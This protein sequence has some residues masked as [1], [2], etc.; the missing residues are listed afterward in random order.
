MADSVS[1]TNAPA[2]FSKGLDGIVAG[3]SSICFIDGYKGELVYR[4][5]NTDELAA[6]ATF[7]E[8]IYLLWHGSLPKKDELLKLQKELSTN[9]DLPEQVITFLRSVPK[10]SNPMDVLRTAVSLLGLYDEESSATSTEANWRKSVRL[11]AKLPTIVANFHRLRSNG[12]YLKPEP[13]LNHSANFLYMINGVEPGTTASKTLDC[14]LVLHADHEFNASTFS[15]R[16]TAATLSDIYSAIT[17][18][19]G[20]LK[21]PLHGGA[22]EDVMNMLLDIKTLNNIGPYL[23]KFFAQK[24]KVPGFGHRVYKVEDPRAKHL[25]KFSRQLGDTIGNM[26]WYEMSEKIEEYVKKEKRLVPN[27]DFYSASTYY[28]LGIPVDLFTPIFAVSR[29]AGWTA[30]VMEQYADNRLIRPVSDYVGPHEVHFVPI[31]K[32]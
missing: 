23:Q 28:Y 9:R 5:I 10:S 18:A 15:A 20:T 8:V 25:R 14:A 22:N 26:K 19:V 7:E 13:S 30:H 21:G 31:D 1:A 6:N 17:S 32:R 4:G 16:V 11:V 2:S 24:K 29:V 27:V 3:Q 12:D